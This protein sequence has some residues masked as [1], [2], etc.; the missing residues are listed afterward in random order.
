MQLKESEQIS[1]YAWKNR[2]ESSHPIGH[3][4]LSTS[5]PTRL[6]GISDP[7]RTGTPYF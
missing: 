2:S 7:T 3:S 4:G 1:R 5:N 6:L